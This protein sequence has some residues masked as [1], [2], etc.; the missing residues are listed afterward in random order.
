MKRSR[1]IPYMILSVL[2]TLLLWIYMVGVEQPEKE[3]TI[4]GIKFL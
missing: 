1:K 2:I 3:E 4:S